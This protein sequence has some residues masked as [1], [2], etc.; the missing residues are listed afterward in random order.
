MVN[1]VGSSFFINGGILENLKLPGSTAIEYYIVN[2]QL[3]TT[4]RL[5]P[6]HT[7]AVDLEDEE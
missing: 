2:I 4:F 5:K 3:L 7:L 6:G 1:F